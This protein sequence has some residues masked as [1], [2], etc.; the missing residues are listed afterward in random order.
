[1][2][3]SNY[4]PLKLYIF[5]GLFLFFSAFL[6]YRYLLPQKIPQDIEPEIN[7]YLHQT[8]EVSR[9][10]FE[11]YLVGCLAAEM[12][13]SFELE[14]L[15]AQAVC[16]RTYA[17]RKLI[18]QKDYPRGADLSDNILDCQAFI[19]MDKY[20]DRHP[21]VPKTVIKKARQAVQETRGEILIYQ[22]M[23][24]DTVYHS[25]CGGQTESARE[26]WGEDLTYLQ[27]V[28]CS[29]C[30][31]SRFYKQDFRFPTSQIISLSGQNGKKLRIKILH[32][33]PGGRVKELEINGQRMSGPE[34]RK[35]LGLPST[36]FKID[37]DGDTTRIQC[38]GYGHGVGLCQ[39]GANGMAKKGLGYRKILKH[40]Y[41][42][43]EFYKFSY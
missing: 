21:G 24:A 4:L 37:I 13:L 26:I 20:Y 9:M 12:P 30:K 23:P 5:I 29:Y 34:F 32:K 7:L 17:V 39:F 1:M 31:S 41:N 22:Q 35:R 25:C 36:W 16:V 27:S 10:A 33:S 15:K 19:F 40:Y 43:V 18:D 11:D 28:P 14:A 2:I 42:E 3:K 8:D 38:R 6:I